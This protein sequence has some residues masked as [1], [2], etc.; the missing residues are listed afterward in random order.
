MTDEQD[1]R[2][3][4]DHRPEAA[5]RHVGDD[6]DQQQDH[7]VDDPVVLVI[8][9]V[10]LVGCIG[11][12]VHLR[13]AGLLRLSVRE[14]DLHPVGVVIAHNHVGLA[15]QD[16]QAFPVDNR[17]Q[18]QQEPAGPHRPPVK[19]AGMAD[20]ADFPGVAREAVGL[21]LGGRTVAIGSSS[22]W[23]P[24]GRGRS[25]APVRPH[26]LI[27]SGDSDLVRQFENRLVRDNRN[28]KSP[29]V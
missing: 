5:Q 13:G 1:D 24:G 10:Q 3:E 22:G 18:D 29:L 19:Q 12:I 7:R 14:D 17:K 20:D 16:H 6:D 23:C 25:A 26:W 27:R 4:D 21:G 2:N 11:G 8:G 9:D 28:V 15:R